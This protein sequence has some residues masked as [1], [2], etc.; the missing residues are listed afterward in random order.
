MLPTVYLNGEY[1]DQQ[2][3]RLHVSDLSILRGYG[4]FDYFRYVDGKPRFLI[5]HLTRFESSAAGLGLPIP[6]SPAELSEIVYQ[7]IE[8]NGGGG[9][10]IRLVLTGGYADDGYTPHHPNLLGLPYA[11]TAPPTS[12]Y[13]RG[14]SVL[15]HAYERQLPQVK[16]ID[17][18]EGIRIQP[19]LRAEG[20]DYPLYVD[21][22]GNVRE[23]DRSNFMIV[24]DGVLTTPVDDIL[25]GITRARLLDLARELSIPVQ[26]TAVSVTDLL[27]AD[28]ALICSSVKGLMPITRV[29]GNHLGG[30]AAG[31]ITSRLMQAWREYHG[32][33]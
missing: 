16:S 20:A 27:S 6:L 26:E 12:L 4:V 17:Y 18:I 5:D 1:L 25:L 2:T 32:R 30:G 10:G 33:E 14:C 3:A 8:R 15:L 28:G 7:L 13:Q 21:R 22:H 11:F 9:G 31:A 19:L 24:R 29:N 23:S